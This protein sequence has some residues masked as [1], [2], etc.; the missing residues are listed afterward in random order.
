MPYVKQFVDSRGV[1]YLSSAWYFEKAII[2]IKT[3]T[4][5]FIFLAYLDINSRAAG[6]TEIG[7]KVFTVEGSQFDYY[8]YHHMVLGKNLRIIAYMIAQDQVFPTGAMEPVAVG[9][10]GI[11]TY[12]PVMA[13]FFADAED[14]P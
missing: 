8:F 7:E 1:D 13:S 14:I 4:A 10:G 9:E 12:Q 2:N 3:K 6:K 5:N 11:P